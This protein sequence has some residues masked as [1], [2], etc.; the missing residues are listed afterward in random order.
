MRGGGDLVHLN[1]K[2]KYKGR[3]SFCKCSRIRS[4]RPV[5]IG[6]ASSARHE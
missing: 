1:G 5:S 6:S 4:A 2:Y 3:G